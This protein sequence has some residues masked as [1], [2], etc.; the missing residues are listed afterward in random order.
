MPT[1]VTSPNHYIF[2]YL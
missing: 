2:S 1:V